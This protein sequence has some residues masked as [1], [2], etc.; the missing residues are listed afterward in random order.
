[1]TGKVLGYAVGA[2]GIG[3]LVL[4][5]ARSEMRTIALPDRPGRESAQALGSVPQHRTSEA[6]PR[7]PEKDM[8]SMLAAL[9]RVLNR[10]TAA[11]RL[12]CTVQ[13]GA[14]DEV[15]LGTDRGII[16]LDTG[17]AARLSEGALAAAIAEG[18]ASEMLADSIP[19]GDAPGANDTRLQA[20]SR[21]LTRDEL[22]GRLVAAAGYDGEGFRGYLARIKRSSQPGSSQL[23]CSPD[24]R[25]E[26]FVRGYQS[27]PRLASSEAAR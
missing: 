8:S 10:I 27:A 7:S 18:V 13:L 21:Q 20:R 4:A 24:Q 25:H 19:R 23:P 16:R 3:V 22:A 6:R 5:V 1:M 15:V 17:A 2:C 26:A 9:D 11:A 14:V 12:H